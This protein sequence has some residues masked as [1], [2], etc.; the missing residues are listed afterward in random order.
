MKTKIKTII[1]IIFFLLLSLIFYSYYYYLLNNEKRAYIKINEHGFDARVADNYFTKERGL[2]GKTR[3]SSEEAMLFVFEKKDYYSFWMKGMNFPIDII[4]INDD[5]IIG[6]EKNVPVPRNDKI[7][8]YRSDEV[9]NFALELNAGLL[10]EYG[11]DI[12]DKIEIDFYNFGLSYFDFYW[13]KITKKV[14]FSFDIFYDL[15][16]YFKSE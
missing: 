13:Q 7:F 1:I 2:S 12:N 8:V 5:R 15:C 3:I 6:L 4:W 11:I 14:Q 9:I 10:D 16:Y